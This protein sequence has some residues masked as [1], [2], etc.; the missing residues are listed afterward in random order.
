MGEEDVEAALAR[1]GASV[2][3]PSPT[4]SRSPSSTSDPYPIY[5]RLR[6]ESAGRL[7]AGGRDVAGDRLGGGAARSPR[8]PE[9]FAADMPGSPIDR[10][11]G[12]PTILTCDGEPHRELRRAVD[13]KLRPREVERYID[14]AGRADRGER[15][16]ALAG[17]GEVELMAEVLRA[18]LGPQPG[19]AARRSADLDD[20]TLRRWFA[21]LADGATNFE[22]DPAKQAAQR[23]R[24]RRDRRRRSRRCSTGSS[25]SRTTA[26]SPTCSTTGMATGETRPREAIVPD[27]SR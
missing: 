3:A 23:R 16:D 11:F 8:E 5:A 22:R 6:A 19:G 26:R 17:R 25:A 21:G 13:P 10:S 2:T 9:L 18:G 4:R 20:E 27:A 14:D 1:V 24:L 15:L 7:G 12:S